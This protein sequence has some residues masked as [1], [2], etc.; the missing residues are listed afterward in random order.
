MFVLCL[1]FLGDKF[2]SLANKRKGEFNNIV[3]RKDFLQSISKAQFLAKK[4]KKKKK[5]ACKWIILIT[6]FPLSSDLV[7]LLLG[8]WI[9][10]GQSNHAFWVAIRHSLMCNCFLLKISF[11]DVSPVNLILPDCRLS[12]I[13]GYGATKLYQRM[14]HS[15]KADNLIRKV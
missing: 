5:Q 10:R 9:G 12:T 13:E 15:S 6:T 11:F 1:R 14:I 7:L 8:Y 2:G 4:W 3:T